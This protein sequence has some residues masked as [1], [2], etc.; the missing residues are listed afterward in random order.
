MIYTVMQYHKITMIFLYLRRNSW[1]WMNHLHALFK[2]LSL[3]VFFISLAITSGIKIIWQVYNNLSIKSRNNMNSIT[4]VFGMVILP[5][6]K[7]VKLYIY[8]AYLPLPVCING[9]FWSTIEYV[10]WT[11]VSSALIVIFCIAVPTVGS[12]MKF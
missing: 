7:K 4:V 9:S 11:N 2:A 6:I 5:M 12:T 3:G 8:K 1:Y 10:R